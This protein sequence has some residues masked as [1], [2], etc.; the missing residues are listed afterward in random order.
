MTQFIEKFLRIKQFFYLIFSKKENISTYPLCKES[1]LSLFSNQK[2]RAI[3]YKLKKCCNCDLVVQSPRLTQASLE[4][5]YKYNYRGKTFQGHKNSLFNRGRRRGEYINKYLLQNDK[6][7]IIDTHAVI[8]EVGCGYGGILDFFKCKYKWQVY[9]SDIDISINRF[10]QNQGLNIKQGSINVFN[11]GLAD[12]VILS[13]VL[14]HISDPVK[15]IR[16]VVTLIKDSGVIYIEVPGIKNPKVINSNLGAQPGH[17]IY[18]DK[19]TLTKVCEK[20]NL[21]VVS[22]NEIVQILARKC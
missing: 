9:G 7:L 18:Y 12:I 4:K 16:E 14:E 13:H 10:S 22:S 15:F 11:K 8:Y 5:Y 19:D 3:N 6:N 2:Y 1:C 17:L 20:E 21:S